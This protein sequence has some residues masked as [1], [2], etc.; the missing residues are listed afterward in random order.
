ML[1]ESVRS[2]VA[3]IDRRYNRNVIAMAMAHGFQKDDAR[4]RH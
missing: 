2:E 1:A 3:L 4:G